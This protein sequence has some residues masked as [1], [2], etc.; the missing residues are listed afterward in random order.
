MFDFRLSKVPWRQEER[1][2]GEEGSGD[3]GVSG[4]EAEF[5]D[6]KTDEEREDNGMVCKEVIIRCKGATRR[7]LLLGARTM[8][9]SSSKYSEDHGDRKEE[10]GSKRRYQANSYTFRQGYCHGKYLSPL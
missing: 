7:H 1:S 9:W 2:E 6:D 3:E 8:I 10:I 4:H 5:G